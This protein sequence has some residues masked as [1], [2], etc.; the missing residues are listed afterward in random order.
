MCFAIPMR[1]I[2][3]RGLSALCD[4]RGA[5]REVSLLM[6]QHQDIAPGDQ[7]TVHLDRAIEKITTEQ[8]EAA[9]AL[10]DLMLA[11]EPG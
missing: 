3:V 1:V 7:V 10:Y 2:T 5:Q 4:A 9:W 11:D 8:A 6:L